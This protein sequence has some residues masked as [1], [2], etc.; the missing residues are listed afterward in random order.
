MNPLT[1]FSFN[2]TLSLYLNDKAIEN[3]IVHN[4]NLETVF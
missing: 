4:N 2:K 1:V 3:N